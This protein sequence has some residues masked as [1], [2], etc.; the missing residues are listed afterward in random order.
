VHDLRTPLNALLLGLEGVVLYGSL[1]PSQQS[2]LDLAK[3][4]AVALRELV[5]RLIEAGDKRSTESRPRSV[6]SS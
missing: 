1:D 5:Q 4:N 2:A 3:C 6:V